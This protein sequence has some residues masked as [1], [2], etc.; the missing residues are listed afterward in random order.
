METVTAERYRGILQRAI[1]QIHDN[2]IQL[3]YSQQDGATAHT[4][5]TTIRYLEEFYGNRISSRPL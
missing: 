5:I 2:E 4:A 3:G 1:D